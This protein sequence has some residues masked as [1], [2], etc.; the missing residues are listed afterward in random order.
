MRIIDINGFIGSSMVITSRSFSAVKL[1]DLLTC[2]KLSTERER[3][4][5]R[6][7]GIAISLV[8]PLYYLHDY[9]SIETKHSD[10]FQILF[11]RSYFINK[12]IIR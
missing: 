2:E 8:L 4:R 5:E 1:N 10:L 3:E 9:R 12:R 6:I 7:L 11:R